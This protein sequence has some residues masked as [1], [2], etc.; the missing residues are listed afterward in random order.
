MDA[1]QQ[2][3][4]TRSCTHTHT[5]T[6]EKDTSFNYTSL[7]PNSPKRKQRISQSTDFSKFD[8]NL[9]YTSWDSFKFFQLLDKHE[10]ARLVQHEL[11]HKGV[12]Q[13]EGPVSPAELGEL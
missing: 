12:E 5:H 13:G 9:T 6:K 8:Q 4:N 1:V 11:L 3:R 7:H 2:Q 10:H